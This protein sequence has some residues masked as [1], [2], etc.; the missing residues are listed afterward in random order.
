MVGVNDWPMCLSTKVHFREKLTFLRQTIRLPSRV[1]TAQ[2]LNRQQIEREI[3]NAQRSFELHK[4]CGEVRALGTTRRSWQNCD[5][6][7]SWLE[8]ARGQGHGYSGA[9]ESIVH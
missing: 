9:L 7:T 4:E 3:S 1:N 2:R 5:Y 8:G 6:F